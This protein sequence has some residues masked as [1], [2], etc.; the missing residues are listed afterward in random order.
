MPTTSINK[1]QYAN[2][3]MQAANSQVTGRNGNLTINTGNGNDN[4]HIGRAN[5][6]QLFIDINGN[7]LLLEREGLT[8]LN[9]GGQGGDDR[10][11]IDRDVGNVP[12]T[13]SGGNGNDTFVSRTNGAHIIGGNGNDTVNVAGKNNVIFPGPGTDNVRTSGT[14]NRVLEGIGAAVGGVKENQRRYAVMPPS[15]IP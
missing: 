3:N 13:V 12:L 7:R 9:V 2:I 11:T 15:R 5:D 8:R 10:F 4:I 1:S 6:N 14:N